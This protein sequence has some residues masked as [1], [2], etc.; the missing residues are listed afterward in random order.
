CQYEG[1]FTT[2]GACNINPG[3][4]KTTA[5]HEVIFIP[6]A[7]QTPVFGAADG[8][9]FLGCLISGD[10]IRWFGPFTSGSI[11]I[12]AASLTDEPEDVKIDGISNT[13]TTVHY[14]LNFT[15]SQDSSYYNTYSQGT[16][17]G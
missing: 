16:I 9:S 7:G 11:N 17:N 3:L 12:A 8:S 13:Q 14:G 1:T 6:P 4:T 5:T 2:A 10:H 15:G